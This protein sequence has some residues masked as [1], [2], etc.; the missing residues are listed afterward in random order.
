MPNLP[1]YNWKTIFSDGVQT[2][3]TNVVPNPSFEIN[4]TGWS[5]GQSPLPSQSSTYA[6][7]GNS[8][9]LTTM[10]SAAD[11][12]AFAL[13]AAS[14][15]LTSTGDYIASG[16]VYIPVGSTLAGRTITISLEGGTGTVTS[17][18][19]NPATLVAGS[20]VRASR[21]F[22]VTA[23]GTKAMVFRLSGT[24]STAIGQTIYLDGVL[25]EKTTTLQP[26]F[27]GTSFDPLTP[28]KYV[29]EVSWSGGV[30]ASA[31]FEKWQNWYQ[32][33]DIQTIDIFRGRRLQIDDYSIDNATI[34]SLDP[35]G[36]TNT[37]RLGDDIQ[38][39]VDAPGYVAGTDTFPAFWG[40]I[41]N[42]DIQYGKVPAEDQVTITCEGLQAEWGRA[43]LNAFSLPQQLTDESILD[44][45][46]EVGLPTAQFGGRSTNSAITFTGNAFDLVNGITR[47]EEAR[48]WAYG[49]PLGYRPQLWWFGR[50]LDNASTYEFNDGTIT[51]SIIAQLYEQIEFRSSA[52]NYYN[53]V[54]ISPDAVAAQT[55][56]LGVT[57]IFGWDK[58]TYDFST[59][60]ALDHA[61][62]V[63]QNFQNKNQAI[64]SISF[65]DI[66]QSATYGPGVPNGVLLT[67]IQV[68]IA[69]KF[70][71]VFRGTK[72]YTIGEGV[73]ISARP[74]QTRF[75]LFVSGQDQNAYLKLDDTIFGTLDFN[76][77]GF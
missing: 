48:M 23:T 57:P 42:V 44:V 58:D 69:T 1:A 43:P 70:A 10:S 63:L 41:R 16:Y 68:P 35:T 39:Y 8:S 31:S 49:Q 32:L 29:A 47:T 26:Y 62:W 36:W 19:S 34:T 27:D 18:T 40:N 24:L 30:G 55:A 21:A 25:E 17:G 50:N 11:S 9:A 2:T 14:N 52:D 75:T 65:T 54:T 45:G 12:N 51:P 13:N 76:K 74:G 7:I 61:Q 5:S 33:P 20:W 60:Q 38:I 56:T 6:Y 64:A 67:V 3:R 59:S 77:L 46:T 53:E 22:T 73:Q 4:M 71:I 72:Y 15:N 37:P 66:Q 28:P